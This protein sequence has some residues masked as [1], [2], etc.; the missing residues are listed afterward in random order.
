SASKKA[1][2]LCRGFF[3]DTFNLQS[4][5]VLLLPLLRI[6]I[7]PTSKFLFLYRAS[8]Q[9]QSLHCCIRFGSV[10][11]AAIQLQK[12]NRYSKTSTLIAINKWMIFYNPKRIA[13]GQFE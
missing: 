2:A 7:Q 4:S 10:E 6:N 9:R 5:K 11:Y 8:R 12:K 1:S 3:I 13:G